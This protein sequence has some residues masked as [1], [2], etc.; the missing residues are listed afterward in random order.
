M[1]MDATESTLTLDCCEL[2]KLLYFFGCSCACFVFLLSK[3]VKLEIL[4]YYFSYRKCFDLS[5]F[6]IVNM[7]KV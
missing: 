5:N 7:G 4:I 3:Q 1:Y 6:E 2:L